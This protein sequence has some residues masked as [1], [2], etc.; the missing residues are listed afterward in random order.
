MEKANHD[1]RTILVVDD[2]RVA[3]LLVRKFIL[4]SHPG[5]I[6]EEASTGEEALEKVRAG[7]Q[8]SLFIIDVNMPGMGGIAAAE[9]LRNACPGTPISLLT[10]NVHNATRCSA[11]ELGIGFMEKPITGERIARILSVLNKDAVVPAKAGT[12]TEPPE[13]AAQ[14]GSQSSTALAP[15]TTEPSG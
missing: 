15:V 11:N 2:S 1:V 10:V 8:P 12:Y 7:V 6:V 14:H 9:R 13:S 3:R 4:E 5:W